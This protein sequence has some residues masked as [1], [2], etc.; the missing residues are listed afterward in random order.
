MTA[1]GSYPDAPLRGFE[2]HSD[3]ASAGHHDGS[4]TGWAHHGITVSS[5][6]EVISFSEDGPTV[7]FL[8]ADWQITHSWN[9]PV[10]A[11]HCLRALMGPD[12]ERLW[13]ADN[14]DLAVRRSQG[15]Y[16]YEPAEGETLH[17]S[18][19][20]L[21]L[22]GEEVRRIGPPPHLA[23][24]SGSFCPT[25]MV[26]DESRL[27]G[28]GDIWIADGYGQNFVHRYDQHGNYL[29]TITGESGA[30]LFIEPHALHIDRRSVTPELWVADRGNS[31]IQVFDLNGMFLRA[32][33]SGR[34]V[35]PSGF[36]GFGTYLVVAELDARITIL[37]DKDQ[38][39]TTI[40]E[41]NL[42][43]RG[44]PGPDAGPLTVT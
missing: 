30:G 34:L 42:P 20:E 9:A 27:G 8:D 25:D 5:A 14:G 22:D 2:W 15:H 40:G 33:G 31:R 36:V 1:E 17:G 11:G 19:V 38:V 23:Y 28:S 3:T 4:S 13:I 26:I 21:T 7:Q 41:Q 10:T 24:L 35:S 16:E 6:G 12:E 18:V 39:V 43:D 37:D 32:V 44:R 29:A